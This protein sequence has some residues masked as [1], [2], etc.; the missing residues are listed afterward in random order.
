MFYSDMRQF[1]SEAF[2]LTESLDMIDIIAL[3]KENDFFFDMKNYITD[4][5]SNILEYDESSKTWCYLRRDK[6]GRDFYQA[7]PVDYISEDE[8]EQ[9]SE[10]LIEDS[11][12]EDYDWQGLDIDE[13]KSLLYD[14]EF[15]DAIFSELE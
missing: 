2:E 8:R 13:V 6:S 11:G 7:V 15:L 5:N 3:A 1:L 10:Y 9:L 14:E 4:P 12:I